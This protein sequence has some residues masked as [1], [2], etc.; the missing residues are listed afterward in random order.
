MDAG[1]TAED[2]APAQVTLVVEGEVAGRYC[3]VGAA[4][5]VQDGVGPLA[6]AGRCQFVD[7]AA[8]APLGSISARPMFLAP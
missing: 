5:A 8:V 7:H 2:S 6:V 1:R 4:K 3:T